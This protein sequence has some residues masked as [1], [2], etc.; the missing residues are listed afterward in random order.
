MA[1]GD[2]ATVIWATSRSPRGVP[3]ATGIGVGGR[4]AAVVGVVVALGG[5]ETV[6][7]GD[8]VDPPQAPINETSVT[9]RIGDRA[10][11]IVVMVDTARHD[12]TDR[13]GQN[14]PNR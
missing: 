5:L 8:G 3:V 13:K 14:A 6:G 10:R 1:H 11:G 7:A 2:F 12:W 4:L 9:S